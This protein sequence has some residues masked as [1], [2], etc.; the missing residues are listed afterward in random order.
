VLALDDVWKAHPVRGGYRDVLKGIT[1][2]IER[3]DAL[4]ILGRNGAGKSTLLRILGGV[5]KPTRGRVQ[6]S[7][8]V[9]WPLGSGI[10]VQASLTGADNAR[11][12]A[13]IYGLDVR[14]TL[15][16]VEAFAELGPYFHE[17]AKSYSSGMMGRLMLGLS[18]AVEFECY[19]VDEVV[20]AGDA[21]FVDKCAQAFDD[22]RSR[23]AL[24][25]VSHSMDLI[26]L[27][28]RRA[29]VLHQGRLR[30]Y[31]DLDEAITAYQSL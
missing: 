19:L 1:T 12:I 16:R 2:T 7:M 4:G 20:G 21:R 17:P 23:A 30:F 13:R 22:R 14:E 8:S 31:D 29:V 9:S 18:F 3:G 26:R 15:E 10:G 27:Y 25:L 24:V 6:R 11:F 28:C 5:D